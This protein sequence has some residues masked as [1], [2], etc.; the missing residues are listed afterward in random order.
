MKSLPLADVKA[1]PSE[2]VSEVEKQ[3]ERLLITRN[4]KAA[5]VVISIGEWE[6]LRETLEILSD[7]AAVA[8]IYEAEADIA[9]GDVY[10]T[11]EV[12]ADRR[13]RRSTA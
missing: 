9:R 1:G 5:A 7:R 2:L 13:R 10:T 6:S 3:R 4:G 8:A 11:E 12:L